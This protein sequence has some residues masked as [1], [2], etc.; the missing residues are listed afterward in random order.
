MAAP[1][2]PRNARLA[3]WLAL[4][5][6]CACRE[7]SQMSGFLP[8][9]PAPEGTQGCAAL[10]VPLA[11]ATVVFASA[12]FGELSQIAA[13][14]G[15]V[16][17]DVLY[18]TAGDGSVHEL[19]V[20]AGGG[21]GTDS[22]LVAAGTIESDYLAPGI[23]PPARLSGI[24]VIDAQRLAVAE[25]ASNTLVIVRRD[26]LDLVEGG[27]GLKL[28][29]GGFSDGT[30]A[31]I[32]FRFTEPVPLL[33][34]AAGTILVGDTGNHAL[35]LVVP[36]LFPSVATAAGN[37]APGSGA[38]EA[39]RLD[40]PSGLAAS[41]SLELLV[42]ESGASGIAGNRLLSLQIREALFGGFESSSMVLAGDGI[43]E[44]LE[45]L[46]ASARLAAPMGLASTADGRV[47]WVDADGTQTGEA[48]LRRYDF[49]TGFSDC[50][51]FPDCATAV[52]QPSD[53]TGTRFSVVIGASG[54][55]YVLGV[56][57]GAGTLWRIGM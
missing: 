4:S 33:V 14:S 20:P 16:G 12:D 45:G 10:T 47:F 31:D 19:R 21:M 24:A 7:G 37:G 22:V 36:G 27:L 52:M 13:A 42:V 26:V 6:L 43:K 18:W 50:P 49:A 55:L 9:V 54:A 51:M 53:L 44:T 3:A 28:P 5:V 23:P 46:D 11:P 38:G 29:S 56:E 8:I 2:H 41:C 17:E 25:H 34:D 48:V 32:S 39:T 1:P 35:R 40:T 57:A 15:T 30:G